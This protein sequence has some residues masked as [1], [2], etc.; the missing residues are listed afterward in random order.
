[1]FPYKREKE[2]KRKRERERERERENK[3]VLDT[4][5]SIGDHISVLLEDD[6]VAF[7]VVEQRQRGERGRYAAGR[8]DVA[9]IRLLHVVDD[10]LDSGVVSRSLALRQREGAGAVAVVGL[11]TDR[12]DDP[13]RPSDRFK[14]DVKFPPA[15]V[16]PADA[17]GGPSL[18]LTRFPVVPVCLINE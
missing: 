17:A 15:A 18:T 8:G 14:V 4:A 7:V 2:R 11:V 3:N 1:M 6:V 10:G 9:R 12:C 13:L 16:I 5:A